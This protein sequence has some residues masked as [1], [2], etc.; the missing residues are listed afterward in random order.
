MKMYLGDRSKHINS[1]T[2]SKNQKPEI[3]YSANSHFQIALI[4]L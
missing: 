3:I 2:D 1:H 4:L